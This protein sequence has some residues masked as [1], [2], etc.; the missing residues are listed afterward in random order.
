MN[1]F[2]F[3]TKID[4]KVKSSHPI[5]AINNFITNVM[6]VCRK[7]INCSDFNVS[8]LIKQHFQLNLLFL[9]ILAV[10]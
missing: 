6:I 8:F 3:V 9:I 10:N 5:I 2:F 4:E 1:Y 7:D